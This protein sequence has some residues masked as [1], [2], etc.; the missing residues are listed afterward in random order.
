MSALAVIHGIGDQGPGFANQFLEDVAARADPDLVTQPICWQSVVAHRQQRLINRN[1]ELKWVRLRRLLSTYAGDAIAYQLT[2]DSSDS[3]GKI[4]QTIDYGLQDLLTISND[5]PLVVVA[6]SLG[7]I[8]LNNFLWDCATPGAKGNQSYNTQNE[9]TQKVFHKIKAVISIGSPL[10]LWT[11]RY[12]S[13]VQPPKLSSGCMWINV[14][15]RYDPLA[16]PIKTINASFTANTQL[17]DHQI[18]CGNLFLHWTPLSHNLYWSDKQVIQLV[19][20]MVK[21]V[22]E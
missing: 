9:A 13:F 18:D 11:L 5:K 17:I 7:S 1:P 10:A 8:I 4:H 22:G 21:S 15:S 19:A 20:D 6:H 12:R 2:G 16:Y 14:Y 3:Y